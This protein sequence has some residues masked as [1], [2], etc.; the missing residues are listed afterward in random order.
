MAETAE[1]REQSAA[2]GSSGPKGQLKL[3]EFGDRVVH[4]IVP[5][6]NFLRQLWSKTQEQSNLLLSCFRGVFREMV[7]QV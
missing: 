4:N 7:C 1:G 6:N 3:E 5:N 2:K